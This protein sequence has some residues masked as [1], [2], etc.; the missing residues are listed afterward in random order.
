VLNLPLAHLWAKLLQIPRPY[1]YAGILFFASIGGYAANGSTVD[2][3]LLA[4]FGVLGFVMRRYGLPVLPAIIGVILGPRAELQL[5][6]ALQI[7]DG[8]ISGLFNTWFSVS[9]YVLVGLV[10]LLPLLVRLVRR[11]RGD[12]DDGPFDDLTRDVHRVPQLD[13]GVG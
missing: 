13:G 4:V 12:G 10:L 1:L 8:E 5:R 7:S 6:R 2:L 11:R 3:V 9:V